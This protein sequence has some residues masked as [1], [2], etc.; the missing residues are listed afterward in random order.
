MQSCWY[1]ILGIE[2]SGLFPQVQEP[3]TV[4]CYVDKIKT[5]YMGRKH[6][7]P[8]LQTVSMNLW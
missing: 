8:N 6:D 1:L 7:G 5:T 3:N 2:D 4:Y